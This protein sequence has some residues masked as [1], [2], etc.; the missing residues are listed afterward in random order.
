[1]L[2]EYRGGITANIGIMKCDYSCDL[3]Y[4]LLKYL[5]IWNLKL[6]EKFFHAENETV[7]PFFFFSQ[8][9]PRTKHEDTFTNLNFFLASACRLSSST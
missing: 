8:G 7:Q 3:S 1:M 4:P 6:Q 5:K 2:T 9:S